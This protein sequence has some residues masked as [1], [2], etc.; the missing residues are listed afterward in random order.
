MHEDS[1]KWRY[2]MRMLGHWKPNWW[3]VHGQ[4]DGHRQHCMSHFMADHHKTTADETREE[5]SGRR[6]KDSYTTWK[7]PDTPPPTCQ[8]ASDNRVVVEDGL[9]N[10][11]P[12]RTFCP[13]QYSC[14]GRDLGL[15][16]WRDKTQTNQ[17]L[18]NRSWTQGRR[19]RSNWSIRELPK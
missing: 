11:K 10:R 13:P 16:P 9:S 8:D 3:T 18:Q 12:L 19:S 14:K 4:I 7:A 15:L 5:R 2:R 1:S 6:C 17:D